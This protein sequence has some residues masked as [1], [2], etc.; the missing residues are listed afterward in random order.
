[1]TYLKNRLSRPLYLIAV[2]VAMSA[3]VWGL[4]TGV[5]WLLNA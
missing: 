3:W 5:Y 1:M 2:L 4:A